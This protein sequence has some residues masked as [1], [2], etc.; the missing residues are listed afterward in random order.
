MFCELVQIWLSLFL[1]KKENPAAQKVA[2]Q[3]HRTWGLGPGTWG[4]GPGTW[5][6]GPRTWD[7][8]PGDG[9]LGPGAWGLGMGTWG[10]GPGAWG[11]ELGAWGLELGAWGLGPGAW[12]LGNV[13]NLPLYF[14]PQPPIFVTT[15]DWGARWISPHPIDLNPRFVLSVLSIWNIL[16]VDVVYFLVWCKRIFNTLSWS[17]QKLSDWSGSWRGFTPS[18]S[19]GREELSFPS[20][21]H[22]GLSTT[23]DQGGSC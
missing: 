11:W 15:G 23:I 6:L 17:L 16:N 18:C 21:S 10:L 7:L 19:V 13:E 12:G 4:L 22:G 2:V 14:A 5:D 1:G 3:R 9:N 8:G 20:Q